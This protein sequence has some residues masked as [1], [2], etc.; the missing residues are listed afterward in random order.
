MIDGAVM[1]KA[2]AVK[3]IA[4]EKLIPQAT[5][6]ASAFGHSPAVIALIVAMML[7]VCITAFVLLY[8]RMLEQEAIAEED[9]VRWQPHRYPGRGGNPVSSRMPKSMGGGEM[10]PMPARQ[11]SIAG[12]TSAFRAPLFTSR[13]AADVPVTPEK[14]EAAQP[15][16]LTQQ[17]EVLMKQ[18]HLRIV[19]P[20]HSIQ[21]GLGVA[22]MS[23]HDKMEL[24][25][26]YVCE[27]FVKLNE[28]KRRI[29]SLEMLM[30]EK[31]FLAN[32]KVNHDL[33]KVR[34][35]ACAVEAR[36]QALA[37]MTRTHA[38]DQIERAYTL[39]DCE[40]TVPKDAVNALLD[41]DP[42]EPLSPTEWAD[43]AE[44][45]LYDAE[46]DVKIAINE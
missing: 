17:E 33:L 32:R 9:L 23:A 29:N 4:A 19:K 16:P 12:A 5:E 31:M 45:L 8:L 20:A 25:T 22:D 28:I 38:P 41:S 46:S 11:I 2:E 3:K 34:R 24:I 14:R 44:Y 27:H 18:P 43:I 13:S 42:I 35:V 36:L 6:A 40:I 26:S 39:F 37:E 15:P 1:A 21:P 7:C 10:T 30:G